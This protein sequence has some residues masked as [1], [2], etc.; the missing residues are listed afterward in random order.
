MNTMGWSISD[1]HYKAWKANIGSNFTSPQEKSA[2]A[3][4]G[5]YQNKGKKRLTST[6]VHLQTIFWKLK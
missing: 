2:P 3:N 1:A 4:F 5:G 6:A